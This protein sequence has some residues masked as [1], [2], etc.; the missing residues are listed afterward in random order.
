[1][2]VYV[3]KKRNHIA[4]AIL[5]ELAERLAASDKSAVTILINANGQPWGQGGLR[6]KL[7]QWAKARG[8]HVVP[9]GLRKNAVISLLEA[10]CTVYEVSGITDQ[11]PQMVEHY[12]VKVNKL[13]LGRAAVIKLD[14]H[15]RAQN[16]SGK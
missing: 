1:M 4:V 16:K 3:Q 5:P 7:Q 15:R 12:A 6:Q 14:A 8:H 13:T 9:H 11:S 10:G 2:R